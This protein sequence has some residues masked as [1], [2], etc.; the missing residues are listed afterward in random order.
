MPHL[1]ISHLGSS[2]EVEHGSGMGA[3][4]IMG[5]QVTSVNF[6]N[7]GKHPAAPALEAQG[8]FFRTQTSLTEEFS[9]EA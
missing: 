5:R 8:P 1:S 4:F 9:V 3:F 7:K 2:N 6:V